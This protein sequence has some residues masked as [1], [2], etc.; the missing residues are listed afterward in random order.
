LWSVLQTDDGHGGQGFDRRRVTTGED[1]LER[2][3]RV[4]GQSLFKAA[5]EVAVADD[6]DGN[7][8]CSLQFLLDWITCEF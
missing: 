6:T 5:A 8:G 1:G 7:H 2:E 4:V 3:I